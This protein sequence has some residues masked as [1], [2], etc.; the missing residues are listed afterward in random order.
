MFQVFVVGGG[1]VERRGSCRGRDTRWGSAAFG[2]L[3]LAA[4]RASATGSWCPRAGERSLSRDSRHTYSVAGLDARRRASARPRASCV[5]ARAAGGVSPRPAV[6]VLGDPVSGREL[7]HKGTR[8]A[9]RKTRQE[10]TIPLFSSSQLRRRRRG[11][12]NLPAH[13]RRLD[14]G[15]HF[16]ATERRPALRPHPNREPGAERAGKLE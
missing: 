11:G 5:V 1:F 2:A 7:E 3:V 15:D 9:W 14:N 6:A 16:L 12:S 4:E 10:G 8:C 13:L